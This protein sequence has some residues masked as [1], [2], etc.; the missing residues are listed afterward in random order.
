VC[1]ALAA[2]GQATAQQAAPALIESLAG[3]DSF[4]SY[5]LPCHGAAGRGDGSLA[6][7]LRSQ[8]TDLTQL[9]ARE[10]GTFP[11]ERL[12]AVLDGSGPKVAAHGGSEMPT[13]AP[14]FRAFESDARA[15]ARIA[16]LLTYLESIQVPARAR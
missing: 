5:C 13:W 16:G 11:R 7:R 10:R 3:R 4:N 2:A 1:A 8:P 14:I 15:A 9:A 6:P 12:R